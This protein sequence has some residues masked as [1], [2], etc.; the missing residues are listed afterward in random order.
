MAPH[1]DRNVIAQHSPTVD[2]IHATPLFNTKNRTLVTK[3]RSL[4]SRNLRQFA[5]SA[6]RMEFSQKRRWVTTQPLAQMVG[7]LITNVRRPKANNRRRG[8]LQCDG[9]FSNP[10]TLLPSTLV[11]CFMLTKLL[12]PL[13]KKILPFCFSADPFADKDRSLNLS[14][15]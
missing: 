6:I 11:P 4:I 15:I 5:G 9:H 1:T 7:L 3:Y 13:P 2:K 12:G 14:S 8:L 10:N